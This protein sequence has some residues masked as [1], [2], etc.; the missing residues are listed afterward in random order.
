MYVPDQHAP[1]LHTPDGAVVPLK[2]VTVNVSFTNLLCESV[3][4]QTY[5]NLEKNPIEAV[6]TFPLTSRAVLLGLSITIGERQLQGIVVEK[7]SA[8]EQYEEAISDGDAAIMLEQVQPGLYTMN[9]GNILENEEVQ[10]SI[11][12]AEL[13]A[14]QDGCLR[15]HLPTTLAPRYGSPDQAGLQPHQIP[16]TDL[17]TENRFQLQITLSGEISSAT[18]TSPSHHISVTKDSGNTTVSLA[19]G[20]A[21]MDRDFILN[22]QLPSAPPDTA[23][24]AADQESG[25]VALASFVP[26]LDT[27][28][29]DEPRSIKIVVDC[30]GSMAGDSIAQAR[31]A[32][33]DILKQLRPQDFFNIVAFGSTNHAYFDHQIPVGKDTITMA[34]RRLRS[35]EADLGGTEMFDALQ[36][37]VKLSGPTTPQDILLITDGEIWEEEEILELMEASNHRVFTIGVGSAVSE[38]FLRRLADIT[39]GACELVVPNEEMS[40]K[41]V[42]HFKRIFLPRA[43]VSVR[44]PQTPQQTIPREFGPAFAG[45]TIHAFA[46]FSEPPAGTVV[47]DIKTTDGHTFSQTVE[48]CP[49]SPQQTEN[50][51]LS[52][53]SLARMAIWRA[54]PET[55]NEQEATALAVRYQLISPYTNYLAIITRTEQERSKVLPQLRKVSQM[56]AAGWGGAGSCFALESPSIF[57]VTSASQISYDMD[58]LEALEELSPDEKDR[59]RQQATPEQFLRGCNLHH[60]SWPDTELAITTFADLRECSLPDRVIDAIRVIAERHDPAIGEDLVVLVFLLAM[61]NSPTGSTMNRSVRRAVKQ[62]QKAYLPDQTLVQLMSVAFSTVSETEW[63]PMTLVRLDDK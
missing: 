10:I 51:T 4:T 60:L 48:L 33:N 61:M 56:L 20:E 23:Y 42:R 24:V 13:C 37:T 5:R 34:R 52:A 25:F 49:P 14:W 17:L 53:D 57:D 2:K 46:R 45:D 47:C 58:I 15:Y 9:I 27:T 59:L 40:E 39:G 22:I 50:T 1:G 63:G 26:R 28:I 62:A 38:G 18:L 3:I 36:T 8:E 41:I 55:T 12:S 7:R 6:Y 35:L 43:Q 21:A 19:Q 32:L 54:L 31:Q 16:E 29:P 30:S 44:W 11:R